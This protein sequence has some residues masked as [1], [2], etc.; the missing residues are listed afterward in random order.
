MNFRTARI[1]VRE[2]CE[3]RFPWNKFSR[4]IFK[5]FFI[6]ISLQLWV[7][8]SLFFNCGRRKMWASDGCYR[9]TVVSPHQFTLLTLHQGIDTFNHI[10]CFNHQYAFYWHFAPLRA[11]MRNLF[12]ANKSH[13]LKLLNEMKEM[14]GKSAFPFGSLENH[15]I[16]TNNNN[17]SQ[18]LPR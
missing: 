13:L 10:A 4:A 11:L 6:S 7:K 17:T 16:P 12:S 8:P 15:L 3:L 18:C 9:W 1:H 2:L 5:S 14:A